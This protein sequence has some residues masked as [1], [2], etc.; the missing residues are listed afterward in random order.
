MIMRLKKALAG[1]LAAVLTVTSASFGVYAETAFGEPG[2]A[3]NSVSTENELY[4]VQPEAGY[5]K[6]GD[7]NDVVPEI[8]VYSIRPNAGFKTSYYDQ[9]DEVSQKIYSN[10]RTVYS[11]GGHGKEVDLIEMIPEKARRYTGLTGTTNGDQLTLSED[12]EGRIMADLDR[13][14]VV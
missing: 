13:K 4:L 11:E 14:S 10:L 9:L 8:S 2:G 6:A 3:D 1:L 5:L 12:S 7:L